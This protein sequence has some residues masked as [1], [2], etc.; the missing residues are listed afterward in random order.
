[1]PLVLLTTYANGLGEEVFFRGALYATLP[2]E[3]AVAASTGVYALATDG[4]PQPRRW[5]WRPPSW[6]R[7]SASSGGRPVA[8]RPRCSPT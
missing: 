4:H 3:R 6:A 5:C 2:H 1:M 7:C 8:S